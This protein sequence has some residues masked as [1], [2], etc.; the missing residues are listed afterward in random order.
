MK[1][2]E[3]YDAIDKKTIW[4]RQRNFNGGCNNSHDNHMKA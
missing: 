4:I 2:L 1:Y 3:K